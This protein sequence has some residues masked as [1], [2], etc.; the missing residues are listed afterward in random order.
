MPQRRAP[1]TVDSL[2]THVN[3][4]LRAF[5]ED[6]RGLSLREKVLR[7]VTIL[8]STKDLGVCVVREHGL[9]ASGARERIRLY[10]LE[11]RDTPIK[12]DELEVVAGISEYARRVRELRVEEGYQIATG[13]S[14]DPETGISLKPDEYLL[15]AEEPDRDA[16][17]RWHVANR[18]RRMNA[19]SQARLLTY[20]KENVGRVVTTEELAYVAKD[21]T[22]FGRRVRELRTEDGWSVATRFTGRPDLR[23][24]EYTL[25]SLERI[26][27]PHDRRIPYDI[28]RLV[29]DRDNNTCRLCGWNRDRWTPVDPRILELHHLQHHRDRGPNEP[30]NL[31]VICSRC[32]D[33]VHAGHL[34]IPFT[35]A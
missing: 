19:G 31:I 35:E 21:R 3:G 6:R 9:N 25:Q 10:L 12:G 16:A 33:K 4:L 1:A 28:Q 11:Y 30:K 29:Y 24:G 26:A 34:V 7:L 23:S 20:L 18:I 15:V 22:E 5:H 14:P 32:H 8:R 2:I 13:A 17:R 27:E